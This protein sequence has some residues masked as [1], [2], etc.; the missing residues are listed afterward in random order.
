MVD[1]NDLTIVLANFG[2]SVGSPALKS[3]PEPTTLTLL[4]AGGLLVLL[5]RVGR[6]RR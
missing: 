6:K 4:P 2:E 3:V 5:V 1:I